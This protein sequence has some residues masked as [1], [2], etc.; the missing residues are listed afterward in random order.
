MQLETDELSLIFFALAH[1]VRRALLY[2]LKNGRASVGELQEPLDVKK[3]MMTKHL[4]ILQRANLIER[5]SEGQQRFSRLNPE[6][7]GKV[8][9]WVEEY[10]ELW[11]GKI[12]RL[13]ELY[14]QEQH[15]RES[16]P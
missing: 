7:I 4:K 15:D 12:N 9:D 6:T 1:P 8:K 5:E 13:E 10:K 16:N 3:P 2:Q 11:Q 14:E